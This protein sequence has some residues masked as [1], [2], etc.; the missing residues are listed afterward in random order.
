[1]TQ[2]H[3]SLGEERPYPANSPKERPTLLAF[4]RSNPSINASASFGRTLCYR[5]V[6]RFVGP[7]LP[8]RDPKIL[9]ICPVGRDSCE[10]AIGYSV[11]NQEQLSPHMGDTHLGHGTD[12]RM[13][14]AQGYTSCSPL[15]GPI[16]EALRVRA[17]P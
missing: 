14:E 17:S 15:A 13:G 6:G 8:A 7:Q 4:A 12:D 11:N 3:F 5:K 9:P 1:M 16:A 2:R 10:I